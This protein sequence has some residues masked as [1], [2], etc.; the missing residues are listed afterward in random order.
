[1][2]DKLGARKLKILTPIRKGRGAEILSH[3]LDSNSLSGIFEI[4][5]RHKEEEKWKV[6]ITITDW[7]QV[8]EGH[9]ILI[10]PD[11]EVVASPVPSLPTC[12]EPIG[13]VLNEDI[14][15]CWKR[16]R[17]TNQHVKK[18]IEDT[19]LVC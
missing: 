12:I 9:A 17:F 18:Y 1:M 19:L 13:N 3:R 4:I 11:G 6:R 2:A 10:H 5:K 14:Q 16:Y 7:N 8:E 15:E